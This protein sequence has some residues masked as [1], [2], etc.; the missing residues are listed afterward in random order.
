MAGRTDLEAGKQARM[1]AE[2]ANE[3]KS[4]SPGTEANALQRKCGAFSPCLFEREQRNS[5]VMPMKQK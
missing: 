5:K 3:R 1:L 4:P 2:A